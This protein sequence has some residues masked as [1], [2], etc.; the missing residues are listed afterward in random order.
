MTGVHLGIDNAK[1]VYLMR[2]WEQPLVKAWCKET[3]VLLMFIT[4]LKR[5][6]HVRSL[7][8]MEKR[9]FSKRGNIPDLPAGNWGDNQRRCISQGGCAEKHLGERN[10]L[11]NLQNFLLCNV[12]FCTCLLGTHYIEEL[13]LYIMNIC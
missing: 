9:I 4:T 3:Q 13:K 7:L 11:R 8:K 2:V 1:C 12:N 5:K 6:Y 10:S